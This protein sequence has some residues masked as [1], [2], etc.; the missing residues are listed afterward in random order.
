M[1]KLSEKPDLKEI[2]AYKKKLSWGDVP[3]IFQMAQGSI[4]EL[5]GTLTHGFDNAFKQLLNKSNWNLALLESYVDQD[6]NMQVKQKPKIALKHVYDEQSYELH[7][8]PIVQG[9]RLNISLSKHP[10]C[11]FEIWVPESMRMLFRINNLIA[12]ILYSFQRGDE[13]DIAL[14]KYAHLKV[15][16]LI[17]ILSE[18]FEV[19]DIIGYNIAEFCQEIRNRKNALDMTDLYNK[20]NEGTE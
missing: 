7:C 18:S 16:H 17:T 20:S 3:S 14:I 5:D 12:F 13:A 11:P 6:G 8:Y 2:T 4:S 1:N 19:V 15:S 9:E 10:Y